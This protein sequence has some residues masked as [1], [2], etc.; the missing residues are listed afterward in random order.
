L[1][2]RPHFHVNGGLKQQ[3]KDK[4]TLIINFLILLDERK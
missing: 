2:H 3:I 1:N 4:R